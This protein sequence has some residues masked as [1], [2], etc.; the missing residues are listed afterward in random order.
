[1]TLAG[2]IV[3]K[4]KIDPHGDGNGRHDLANILDKAALHASFVSTMKMFWA[5]LAG[6]DR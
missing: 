5:R 6:E 2:F 4:N 1:M 3:G